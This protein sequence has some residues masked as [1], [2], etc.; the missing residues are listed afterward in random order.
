MTYI[1]VAQKLFKAQFSYK[2]STVLSLFSALLSFFVQISL[3]SALA[4]SGNSETTLEGMVVFVMINTFVSV[5]TSANI[6]SELEPAIR[7]G[8]ISGYFLRPV[9]FKYYCFSEV[10]GKNLYNIL[11]TALPIV[12][13]ALLLFSLPLPSPFYFMLFIISLLLG[14]II[15]LELTYIFGLLAFFTQRAWYISWYLSAFLTFF[16][17]TAVPLWYYPDFLKTISSFLP[18]KYVSFEPINLFLEKTTPIDGVLGMCIA[19]FWILALNLMGYAIYSVVRKRL[20]V[21]GG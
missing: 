5:A 7:D 20:S 3:W 19:V 21:N 4:G 8:S 14:C 9:S 18:F 10:I 1:L 2:L 15:M 12:I 13:L 11:T 17:G 6:A 16:G